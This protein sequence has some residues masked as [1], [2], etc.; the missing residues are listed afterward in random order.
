MPDNWFTNA[1]LDLSRIQGVSIDLTRP[2]DVAEFL[3]PT[4]DIPDET[5]I[6]LFDLLSYLTSDGRQTLMLGVSMHMPYF[7]SKAAL[8]NTGKALARLELSLLN[9]EDAEIIHYMKHNI[10][11]EM[12]MTYRSALQ[13]RTGYAPV[14]TTLLGIPIEDYVLNPENEIVKYVHSLFKDKNISDVQVLGESVNPWQI[15]KPD[16]NGQNLK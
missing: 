12:D 13:K 16:G 15:K 1:I 10:F 7:A 8:N 6:C 4:A 3:M 5:K 9:C 14:P 11:E 2:N